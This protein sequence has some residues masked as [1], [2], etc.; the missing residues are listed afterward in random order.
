MKWRGIRGL[1]RLGGGGMPATGAVMIAG[2]EAARPRRR[3]RP[4][5]GAGREVQRASAKAQGAIN[6]M[7]PSPYGVLPT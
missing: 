4:A 3:G 6:V 1:R 7:V 2:K 5:D